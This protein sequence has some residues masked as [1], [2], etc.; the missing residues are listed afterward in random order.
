MNRRIVL[1]AAAVILALVGTF[2]VYKY[3]KSADNRAIAGVKPATVLVVTKAIPLGTTWSD[4]L[5]SGSVKQESVPA[6]AAPDSAV[7]STTDTSM[8]GTQ[9]ALADIAPGQIVLRQMFG[10]QAAAATGVVSIP[11]GM[12]A[13]SVSLNSNADV[14]GYV[15]PQSQ[16]IVFATA[17]LTGKAADS[18]TTSGGTL[19]M[20]KTLLARV[21]VIATSAAAPTDL[22]GAKSGGSSGGSVMVTLALTQAQAER[23]IL[24]QQSGQLYLGLLSDSSTVEPDEPGVTNV[25]NVHPAPIFVK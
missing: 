5:G 21:T 22:N 23:L 12:I 1:I 8:S 2:A 9:V 20:T 18:A 19:A 4:A 7:T 13:V 3:A 25:A 24:A 14:A 17:N 16:V 10:T 15:Q 6:D 11:K